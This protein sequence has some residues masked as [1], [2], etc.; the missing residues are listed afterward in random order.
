MK[1]VF[2]FALFTI[3]LGACDNKAKFTVEGTVEGAQDSVLY[4][5]Q[6]SLS[7]VKKLDSLKLKA[8]GAFRFTADTTST[9]EFYVLRISDQIINISVDST[10]TITIRAQYPNMAAR[11]EVEGSENCQKIRSLALMQQELLRKSIALEQNQSMPP[12]DAQDSL[13]RMIKRHKEHVLREYIYQAPNKTYSYFAL[14]QTLGPWFIFNPQANP[15][16]LRVFAA[17]ATS[18]DTFHPGSD[19]TQNLHNIVMEQMKQQRGNQYSA[20]TDGP[21]IVE[22]GIIELQLPDNQQK[23]QTLG[24][25][26]GRVVLLDFHSFALENSPQ[27]ILMLRDL[28]NKYHA[29]GLEIYQVSLDQDE[30]F[31][32]QMTQHLPW[33]CVRDASLQSAQSYNVMEV[34]EFFLID[35]NSQLQK[36]SSQIKDLEKE[37]ESML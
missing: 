10:E 3:L 35:R 15:E 29:R 19:R 8:D 37:I 6:M 1:K 33:I 23:L 36:R 13:L 21:A 34:P 17:V 28:Y 14:F 12:G 22:S 5:E 2:L 31:W 27:R 20:G 32:R 24:E 25:L 26:K 30:H 4:F 9:P 11:Y 7:G 18:W 16:D